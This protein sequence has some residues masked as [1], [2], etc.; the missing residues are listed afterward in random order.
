MANSKTKKDN[1]FSDFANSIAQ[2]YLEKFE[3]S[4]INILRKLEKIESEIRNP[5]KDEVITPSELC[6]RLEISRTTLWNYENKGYLKSIGIG[7]RRYY[8]WGKVL[9]SLENSKL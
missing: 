2:T 7:A 3:Q 1:P 5:K 4:E 6:K 8:V 9:E